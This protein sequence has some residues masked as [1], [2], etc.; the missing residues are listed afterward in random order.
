MQTSSENEDLE[1]IN[2]ISHHRRPKQ[3][4]KRENQYEKWNDDEIH[5]KQ[6]VEFILKK[7]SHKIA[8]ST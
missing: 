7:I 3:F 6:T 5:S 2:L 1:L 4:P 8:L